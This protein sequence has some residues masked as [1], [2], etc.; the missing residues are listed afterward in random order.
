[1][2][3]INRLIAISVLI[4]ACGATHAVAGSLQP[5]RNQSNEAA[6]FQT[7]TPPPASDSPKYESN[8]TL[9]GC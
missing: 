3:K 5:M 1:M 6:R 9:A 7:Q 4:T 2:T 8:N